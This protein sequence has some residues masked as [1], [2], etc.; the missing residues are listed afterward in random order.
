MNNQSSFPILLSL[1]LAVCFSISCNFET[2]F[3][4]L[5][6]T[7]GIAVDAVYDGDVARV[8][9]LVPAA[10][11]FSGDL[12]PLFKWSANESALNYDFI[13]EDSDGNEI[14]NLTGITTPYY[15]YNSTLTLSG[16]Y[17]WQVR[18]NHTDGHKGV[19]QGPWT[20]SADKII[21]NTE[22]K[23]GSNDFSQEGEV[24]VMYSDGE[25]GFYSA[26][27]EAETADVWHHRFTTRNLQGDWSEEAILDSTV[28]N[29]F[30]LAGG[31]EG[32]L[33]AV[34]WDN[35]SV[36]DYTAP[37]VLKVKKYF[38]GVWTDLP[39][40]ASD[41]IGFESIVVEGELWIVYNTR[42]GDIGS[43]TYPLSLSRYDGSSWS[44]S[45]L[46]ADYNLSFGAR[47]RVGVNGSGNP[48][49]LIKAGTSYSL[50]EETAPGTWTSNTLTIGAGL[51]ADPDIEFTDTAIISSG[52]DLLFLDEYDNDIYALT[53]SGGVLSGT[54]LVEETYYSH[55]NMPDGTIHLLN[56]SWDSDSAGT[57]HIVYSGDEPV[58]GYDNYKN[59]KSTHYQTYTPSASPALSEPVELGTWVAVADSPIKII[60]PGL[61]V[62]SEDTVNIM[63]KVY[64]QEIAARYW[65]YERMGL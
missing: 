34:G 2:S 40:A 18:T 14:E 63:Y 28:Y 22:D 43:Y 61:I 49:V 25:G 52:S 19:W 4:E 37:A 20:F 11:G 44:Y 56:F 33:Y 48:V 30:I 38:E 58:S 59:Y 46:S 54:L 8:N 39:N 57:I 65:A 60:N 24:P 50:R 27:R 42:A 47:I 21:E 3:T 31:D 6:D 45:V 29:S 16:N 26:I 53:I 7:G 23:L 51:T 35:T 10:S 5:L 1:V 13:L 62:D 9:P 41:V 64:S 55:F 17:S 32:E 36:N 15:Q 12:T